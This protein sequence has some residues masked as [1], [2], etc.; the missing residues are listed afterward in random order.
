LNSLIAMSDIIPDA[1][2]RTPVP[3]GEWLP[4]MAELNN[5]GAVEALNVL[6]AEGGYV[7]FNQLEPDNTRTLPEQVRG[8]IAVIDQD[9]VVQLFAGTV[10]GVYTDNGPGFVNILVSPVSAAVA[11]K[12]V[13]VNEQMVALHPDI[14][15]MR[16][17]VDTTTAMVNVGG[18]PPKAE[19]GAQVG[20]FLMLGNLHDDPDDG[21]GVF[22]ARVRW[23]GFNNVDDPW[24]SDPITQADFQDMPAAGG[25][26]RAISGREYGTIFQERMISRAIYRGAP[27]I[28]DIAT[29]E[30]KRGCIARDSIVDVGAIQLGL[31]EDGFFMWNGTDTQLIG[32]NKVNRYFFNK[33]F[34]AERSRIAGAVDLVNGCVLWAF[35]TDSSGLLNEII[36]YSYKEDKWSHSIQTLEFLVDSAKSNTTLEELTDPLESYLESFDSDIYRGGGRA[37]MAAFNTSHMYGLYTGAPQAATMDTAESTGPDGRRVFTNSVRPL[38]DLALP[39]AT[40]QVVARDQMIGEPPAFSAEVPQEIDGQCPVLCD[41]RYVRFRVNLP[42]DAIWRHALGVEVARKASGAF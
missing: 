2:Q 35:P 32:T 34:Y 26:V 22:P 8:A 27:E 29:I 28:F 20:D 14:F 17:P 6:P 33:L 10:G 21:H 4:D 11:W 31:A 23:G 9:D 36:I 40:V 18:N 7:P 15:P 38:V 30:D 41:G 13:R 16:T 24:V 3:F 1:V 19:C 5:P 12:F 37:N 42:A 39:Q 25:P